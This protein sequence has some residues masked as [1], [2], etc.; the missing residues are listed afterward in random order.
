M[1]GQGE[2]RA[3]D[4]IQLDVDQPPTKQARRRRYRARVCALSRHVLDKVPAT[5]HQGKVGIVL[6]VVVR[7]LSSLRPALVNE[8]RNYKKCKQNYQ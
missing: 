8:N 7:L 1:G 3:K 6:E 5:S 4:R 2:H